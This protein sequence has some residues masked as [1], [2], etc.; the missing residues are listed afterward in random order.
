MVALLTTMI[1]TV[2]RFSTYD[3]AEVPTIHVYKVCTNAVTNVL[4]LALA[5]EVRKVS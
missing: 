3:I 4:L 5:G 1:S 2:Q